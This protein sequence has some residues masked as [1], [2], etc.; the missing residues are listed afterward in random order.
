MKVIPSL[1]TLLFIIISQVGF[2]QNNCEIITKAALQR[3]PELLTKNNFEQIQLV[4]NT[5]HSSCQQS[6]LAL[7][8]EIL[9]KIIQKQNSSSSIKTYLDDGY[10]DILIARYDDAALED[11]EKLYLS[12]PEKYQYIPLNSLIDSLIQTKAMALLNSVNYTL[13]RDELALTFLFADRID[14]FY[15]EFN[16]NMKGVR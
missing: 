10:A 12:D 9:N 15:Y 4:S 3:L 16:K 2:S 7:R 6:E 11:Y 13:N 5:L 14:E 8:L 1:I